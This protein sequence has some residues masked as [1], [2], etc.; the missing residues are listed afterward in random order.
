MSE[1]T[2]WYDNF[3]GVLC[4]KYPKKHRLTE[5]LM[6]LLRMEREAVYRRLRKDVMFTGNEIA[7]VAAEWN[8]SLDKIIGTSNGKIIFQLE[9]WNYLNP[10][11]EELKK[12]EKIPQKLDAIKIFPDMEYMEISNK[13]PR[14]LTAGF[15]YL[16]RLYLLKWMYQYVNT[17]TLPFSKVFFHDR[18]EKISADFYAYSK[19]LPAITFI[20]D[21]MI[22]YYLVHDIYYFHSVY[23]ITDEEKKLLKKE[24]Y[25]LVEYIANVASKG[26]W[27]ETNNKVNLYIS[28][29]NIDT[30]YIY[31]YF[32]GAVQLCCVPAF[33]KNE[34]YTEDPLIM[35]NFSAWM[36]AKKKSSILISKADEKSRIE[37][38]MKQRQLI[39]NL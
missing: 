26:C 8:I 28:H 35:N 21:N 4:E 2:S 16:N 9:L 7:T 32:S 27:P 24:L 17:D 39:D 37:F 11:E 20:W 6:D 5:A 13:L 36:Q 14:M 22:F 10:S 29:L 25:D 19:N 38:F 23:L 12:M 1:N 31:Y 33:G 30:N 34:I 3:L 15:P 18:I